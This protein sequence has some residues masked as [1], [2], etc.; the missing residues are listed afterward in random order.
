MK[1]EKE[2]VEEYIKAH[3]LTVLATVSHDFLPEASVLGFAL[4]ENFEIFF[5]TFNTSRKWINLQKNPKVALVIGWEK[6]KTVQYE[7]QAK[8]LG[9]SE[10]AEIIKMHFADRPTIAKY[11][12]AK[13]AALFKVVPKWIR[14]SDSSKDPADTIDLTF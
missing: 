1:S 13:E 6:G 14:Y 2:I 11:L 10:H 4:G 3:Q 5:S 7:G 9:Q 8:E 12:S